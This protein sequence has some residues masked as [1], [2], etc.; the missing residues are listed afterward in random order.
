MAQFVIEEEMRDSARIVSIRGEFSV[1]RAPDVDLALLRALGDRHH[2]VVV[3]LAECEFLDSVALAT[4]LAAYRS[5]RGRGG[6]DMSI[7]SP[8]G[9]EVRARL[10]RTGLDNAIPTFDS[11]EDAVSAAVAKPRLETP[12]RLFGL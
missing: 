3:S 1:G 9:S 7:V 10:T 11:V 4:L 12:T 2:G 5:G 8:Y 6:A